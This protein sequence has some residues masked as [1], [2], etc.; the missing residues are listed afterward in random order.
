MA[1]HTKL[2]IVTDGLILS[3]DPYNTK[4]YV[5]GGTVYDLT[6][7]K[8][9]GETVNGVTYNNAWSLDGTNQDVK[10]NSKLGVSAPTLPITIDLWVKVNSFNG[11]VPSVITLDKDTGFYHGLTIQ[12]SSTSE[13]FSFSI[14]DGT[15]EGTNYRRTVTAPNN[16]VELGKWYHISCI[17][18]DAVTFDM[19]P[20]VNL[21]IPSLTTSGL[22]TGIGWSSSSSSRTTLGSSWG[23]TIR[24]GDMD[25][26]QVKV[27]N[28]EL[29]FAE[30]TQ[31]YNALKWRFI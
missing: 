25:I 23:T 28:R 24:Y 13:N 22:G 6:I 5:S 29:S 14:G 4:S 10:I 31:N 17:F 12:C 9:T 1:Y 20:Y 30:I 26:S 8:Y 7:N 11:F 27:Y 3:V 16:S 2:P 21:V 19:T 15:G 18:R